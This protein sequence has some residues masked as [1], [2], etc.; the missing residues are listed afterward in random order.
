MQPSAIPA[1]DVM[2]TA[3]DIHPQRLGV[4]LRQVYEKGCSE[5]KLAAGAGRA[6]HRERCPEFNQTN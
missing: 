1:A 2:I 4:R 3:R 5:R 6:Y